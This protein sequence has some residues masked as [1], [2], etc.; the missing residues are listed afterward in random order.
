M[1]T[2]R[3]PQAH[4]ALAHPEQIPEQNKVQQLPSY[5]RLYDSW[6]EGGGGSMCGGKK[7]KKKAPR[8]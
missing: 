8:H 6:R 2:S 4:S 7:K 5:L 1:Y 3:I